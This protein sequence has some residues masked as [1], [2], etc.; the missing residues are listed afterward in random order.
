MASMDF[1]NTQSLPR[2]VM[3]ILITKTHLFLK[4][5]HAQPTAQ[6]DTVSLG[7]HS[8][9]LF[10]TL[11]SVGIIVYV[12]VHS[13]KFMPSDLCLFWPFAKIFRWRFTMQ[14]FSVFVVF[15]QSWGLLNPWKITCFLN[16]LTGKALKWVQVVW[17]QE[18]KAISFCEP[19]SGLLCHV[20]N[21]SPN[22]K[23]TVK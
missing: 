10:L 22:S 4:H 23:E 5:L 19:F 14:T 12:T 20:F 21:H 15:S 1:Q 2:S 18:A 8:V 3:V 17:E 9:H 13:F 11:T 16:L 6:K 7:S